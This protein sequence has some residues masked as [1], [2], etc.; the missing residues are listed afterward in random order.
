MTVLDRISWQARRHLGIVVAP[1][2]EYFWEAR[3]SK[4]ISREGFPSW[5]ALADSLEAGDARALDALA[6]HL[7]TN[8]TYFFREERHFDL[9][10]RLLREA[11]IRAPRVWSAAGSTGEE[12]YS[13][14]ITLAEAGFQEFLILVSDVNRRVLAEAARG[15]YDEARLARVPLALRQK[16]FDS[17]GGG[18]YRVKDSL[19][20]HLRFRQLNLMQPLELESPLDAVFC[21]NLLI[22]FDEEG[23]REVLDRLVQSLR[24]GGL[25]FLGEAEGFHR[26]VGLRPVAGASVSRK[27]SA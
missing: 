1:R 18:L 19:H 26:P 2:K 22:Y 4:L 17:L 13:L 6:R 3:L 14:A 25:L 12:G 24:P 23:I 10:P 15:Q 8:H 5:E 27:E 9:L 21:R 20:A 11:G 16:Y 7:T